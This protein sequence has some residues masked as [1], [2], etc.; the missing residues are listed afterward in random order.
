MYFLLHY[1]LRVSV[2]PLAK[3]QN[4]IR[5][6]ESGVVPLHS[7]CTNQNLCCVV[8]CFTFELDC[9]DCVRTATGIFNIPA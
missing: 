1:L 9:T 3:Y 2:H 7:G 6:S 8:S 4:A 5:S